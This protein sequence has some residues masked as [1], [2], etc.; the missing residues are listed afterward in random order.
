[1]FKDT[2]LVAWMM[3]VGLEK[4]SDEGRMVHKCCLYCSN[5]S[6]K[7][8]LL[9]KFI[10]VNLSFL[11]HTAPNSVFYLH[12]SPSNS[13]C[14]DGEYLEALPALLS[15]V[16]S[17]AA[18]FLDRVWIVYCI[19]CEHVNVWVCGCVVKDK[20]NQSLRKIPG[21]LWKPLETSVP[22]THMTLDN[23]NPL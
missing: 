12:I 6:T 4:L 15:S 1:M 22:I 5:P 9:A 17:W 21:N 7:G 23:C 19:V 10:L 8:L 20:P 14:G 13:T 11:G 18:S 3:K 16:W 2:G